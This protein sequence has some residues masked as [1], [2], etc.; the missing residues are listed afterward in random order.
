[1]PTRWKRFREG[2]W[3]SWITRDAGLLLF[4]RVCMSAV[5]ALAGV[6]VPIYLAIIGFNGLTLGLLFTI[7]AVASAVLSALIGLFSDRLGR[8]P[9]L[10]IVPWLASIAAIVF[11]FSHV[12]ALLFVC[13]ALGSFGRGA[14]A[15]AGTIGPY[16]P[17]EQALLAET[18]PAHYRNSL[19]GR[20]AF[21]SSLG[22]LLGTGPLIALPTVVTAIGLFH[23]QGSA[24]YRFLF[25]IMAV[26]AFLAGLLAVALANDRP[27]KM[28]N[29]DSVS[30][31]TD[32]VTRQPRRGRKFRVN[33]SRQSWRLLLRLGIT[34]S[35]NGFA[36]GFFGP[37]ITYWFYRRYNI[38]P[39]TIGLLFSLINL[40]ALV[41]NLSAARLAACLGLVRAIVLS[42][43]LQAILIVPMVLAPTFWLA[44][45]FYFL[46]MFAQRMGLPLRQ[47]YV[48]GVVP[49][50]ERGTVGAFSNLP[51]QATSAASP[52]LAGYLF[53]HVALALPFEIGAFLQGVNTILFFIFFHALLP[54]E[55]QARARPASQRTLPGQAQEDKQAEEQRTHL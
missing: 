25:L 36:V 32:T 22:A 54:P 52:T 30:I 42:R 15:G 20:I 31:S 34:N 28:E 5:R 50:E 40:G 29:N 53:D 49:A 14:G 51:S 2:F 7:V 43:A 37:F 46:R 38:E 27:A 41:A 47:S 18:V 10:I 4:A 44:G 12:V 19:F 21:A 13:A 6:V 24:A 23:V 11:A 45:V 26:V 39:V 8:K 17:A 48:M 1:M 33:I 55:E 16:Q 3:P 9:F 35:V